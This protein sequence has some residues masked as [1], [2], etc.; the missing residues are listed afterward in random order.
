M[1]PAPTHIRDLVQAYLQRHP[2]ERAALT[3]LLALL[4]TGPA[5]TS[6]ATLP[7]H[8]TCSA[9]VIRPDRT[10]LHIHHKATGLVICPGGHV[11]DGDE[12]LL[13]TALREVHEEAGIPPGALCLTPQALAGPIDIDINNIDAN[14]AKGESA[15]QHYDFRFAF[16]L[17]PDAAEVALQPEEVTGAEWRPLDRVASPSLRAKLAAAA[18]TGEAEPVNASI[19]IHDGA[20]HYLLH[21]RDNYPGR[22]WA[23]GEWSL[24]G[25]GREPQDATL[26]DTLL[27]EL[28]E[29]AP[30]LALTDLQPFS[31]ERVTGVDGLCVPIRIHTARWGGDPDTA[32]LREGVMLRWFTPDM[33]HRLLLR[34]STIEL[35]NRHAAEHPA[36]TRPAKVPGSQAVRNVVGVH[37]Y[38]EDDQGRVM[39]GLRHPDSAFAPNTWHLLAGHCEQESAVA[40]L[41]REAEE[42]AGLVLDPAD[43]EFAHA[44]HLV[45]SPGAQ[46]RLGLFF[47]VRSWKGTPELREPDRCTAWKW[48]D[49]DD[50]P[51]QLV[52]YTRDAI[53]G[54]RAGRAYTELGW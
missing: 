3:P 41:I 30:G 2:G 4:D 24:L 1:P 9:V 31:V 15:H 51:E 8:V 54:I 20:G 11:E 28:A 43:V 32:D 37:L 29:E 34:P 36:A 14:P 23:P 10:V 21:L 16:C 48:W 5:P 38:L 42:E 53:A 44:V 35:V 33:L 47:K 25:G 52:P 46:P 17:L 13:A 39:L 7:A 50:L 45:D 18:V 27:R 49:P 12:T 26:T 19:L 22:I 40:C 6:R